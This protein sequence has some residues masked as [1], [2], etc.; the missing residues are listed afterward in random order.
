MSL[1]LRLSKGSALTNEEMDSNFTFLDGRINTISNTVSTVTDVTIPA[2]IT[3][4]NA[5]L[6]LKQNLNVRLTALT[7]AASDGILTLSGDLIIPRRVVAGSQGITVTNATGVTGDITVDVGSSVLTNTSTHT[8]SNKTISGSNN[9]ITNVSLAS[10]VTGTLPIT[11]GGT[12]ATTAASARTNLDVLKSP[13]GTGIVVKTGADTSTT[14]TLVAIGTGIS[15]SISDGVAGNITIQ[16]N[17]TNANTPSTVVA[18]DGNGDFSANIITATLS[19]SATSASTA[20]TATKL[21]TAR[22]INGVSFDGTSNITVADST[23]LPLV[24]GTLTGPLVLS[25]NPTLSLHAATKQYVDSQVSGITTADNTKVPLAGGSMTGY[26]SLSANPVNPLHAATK[27]YVDNTVATATA[28]FADNTKLPLAGGSLSGYLSLNAN[29]VNPLHA[30]TKQYVDART[31]EITSG[32]AT[33]SSASPDS[34]IF[35]PAGKT[36]SSLKGF[37]P[38]FGSAANSVP[39]SNVNVIIAIDT[40]G[41]AVGNTTYNGIAQSSI[42]ASIT[43]AKYLINWYTASG[44]SSEFCIINAPNATN[45]GYAW[46]SA[47]NAITT[48]NNVT[49]LSTGS[50]STMS[51]ILTSGRK[52]KPTVIY[53]FSDMTHA[54]SHTSLFEGNETAWKSWLNTNKIVSYSICIDNSGTPSYGNTFAYDGRTGSDMAG[55]QVLNDNALPTTT[56]AVYNTSSITWSQLSDR[57]RVSL[58]SGVSVSD[59]SVN[60]LAFWQ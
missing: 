59:T 38:A 47:A 12:G 32:T 29:P 51:T 34:D 50:G 27:Q 37:L 45:S 40:S 18:R 1:I 11:N 52:T 10:A 2:I 49:T 60:W 22:T 31:L 20:L 48:V 21:V 46:T 4:N 7:D 9:T 26:L 19:G 30:V 39:V 56:P 24:G 55:I 25:G 16:S 3:N 13:A 33:V 28:G 43:A 53:F 5:S 23:K 17:A 41:S 14:R 6:A 15:V 57:I 8:I 54:L 36:M 42:N 44:A 58:G 35:P